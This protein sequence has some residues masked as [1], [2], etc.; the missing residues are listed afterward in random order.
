MS[1]GKIAHPYHAYMGLLLAIMLI[2]NYVHPENI[3][4]LT[5]T[6]LMLAIGFIIIFT[7]LPFLALCLHTLIRLH[8]LIKNGAQRHETD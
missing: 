1:S 5:S 4:V 7:V 8:V 6:S 3:P 2:A